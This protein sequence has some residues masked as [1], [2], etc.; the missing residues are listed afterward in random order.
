MSG[1]SQYFHGE[2]GLVTEL[3]WMPAGDQ[4][5]LRMGLAGDPH[6]TVAIDYGSDIGIDPLLR[7][8]G[9]AIYLR[10]NA[11]S[12]IWT[13]G[14]HRYHPETDAAMA[15]ALET[16]SRME[17]YGGL[18]GEGGANLRRWLQTLATDTGLPLRPL[19]PGDRVSDTP[20][21]AAGVFLS[22][23]SQNALLAQWLYRQLRS[24]GNVGVWFDQGHPG[25]HPGHE[26]GIAAWLRASV[27]ECQILALLLT[28]PALDSPWVRR[29]IEYAEEKAEREPGFH[30]VVLKLEDVPLPALRARS[31][32]VDCAGMNEGEIL[33]NTYAAVY[34]RESH[35]EWMAEQGR[36][37]WP[38]HEEP[39]VG[40][41]HL[42]SAGGTARALRWRRSAGEVGWELEYESAGATK[43]VRGTGPGE[44][45]DPGIRPGD[46]IGFFQFALH[47]PLWMRSDQ[48][49]LT[50][51]EVMAD[52][53]RALAA[54]PASPRL[55]S[56]VAGSYTF[57]LFLTVALLAA[58]N[59]FAPGVPW[60][61]IGASALA[62]VAT[63]S[64]W[65][66]SPEWGPRS[67][68]WRS[69]TGQAIGCLATLINGAAAMAVVVRAFGGWDAPW[70]LILGV[71]LALL[72][73]A[74]L[75]TARIRDDS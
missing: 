75:A 53:L 74:H 60:W 68:L 24:E 4:L 1:I 61:L 27:Q 9:R 48:L 57:F 2:E 21:D 43:T 52:Y 30:F 5:V 22:Y 29:E 26:E 62:L 19:Q 58:R 39:S 51:Q 34:R 46:R 38:G 66:V 37:G 64:V 33:E 15:R 3:A 45:V 14:A 70:T 36:R 72:A 67:P 31:R 41:G 69:G 16:R 12:G 11:W 55:R 50:P 65:L 23:S 6:R 73:G 42:A 25:E 8:G 28:G 35:R 20:L 47:T 17:E 18:V 56:L 10:A 49:S 7:P 59:D 63:G 13:A 32:V 40:Y 71:W 44:A 54:P